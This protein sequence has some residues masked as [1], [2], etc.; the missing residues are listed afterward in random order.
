MTSQDYKLS[1]LK[2]YCKNSLSPAEVGG[3]R[4]QKHARS[5]GLNIQPHETLGAVTRQ[6]SREKWLVGSIEENGKMFTFGS[7]TPVQP[8][9]SYGWIELLWLNESV[10]LYGI[11]YPKI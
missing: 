4:R 1:Y 3:P 9:H 11:I 5:S 10:H 8:A 7:C 2:G 6:L